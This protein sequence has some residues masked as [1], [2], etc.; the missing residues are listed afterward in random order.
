VELPWTLP[1]DHTLFT[2][3]R[4]RDIEV[5]LCQVERLRDAAGLIQPLTH[6]DPG[7]LG[8]RRNERLYEAFLDRMAEQADLWNA[9]PRDI[10]RWWRH[11]DRA[12]TWSPAGYGTASL[13]TEGRLVFEAPR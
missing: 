13:T 7:Y 11:R 8:E 9:L 6:P 2:L 3:L 12:E 5:W 1:Q 4:H 10:A